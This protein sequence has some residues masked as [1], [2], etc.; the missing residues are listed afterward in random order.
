MKEIFKRV[1]R[2]HSRFLE[3]LEAVYQNCSCV[4]NVQA[5]Y[6]R[7][8]QLTA[9]LESGDGSYRQVEDHI[10]ELKAINYLLTS[11]PGCEITYEPKGVDES[12]KDCDFEVIYN[13][14]RYLVEIK[15]FHPE[16]RSKKIPTEHIADNNVVS[17]NGECY[18]SYQATR[19]HL[20]DVT[21]HTEEKLENYE[22][23]FISVLGVPDGFHLDIEDLR[24]FV[25]IRLD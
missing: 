21:Y 8:D 19:G 22:G 3:E 20:V 24:D 11:F 17:M 23:Q 2:F 5:W 16:W 15:S 9:A 1:E 12:G 6:N 4:V 14:K 18:H 7:F 10:F 13:D 25:F